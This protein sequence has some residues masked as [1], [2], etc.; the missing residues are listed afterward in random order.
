MSDVRRVQ[1][2]ELFAGRYRIERLL[3]AGGMGAVYI[4]EHL[5]TRRKLALKLMHPEIVA[6][7][8][9]REKFAQEAQ[10]AALIDSP[11]IVD[12]YDAGVDPETGIP[13]IAMELL[14]G[15]EL[16]QMLAEEGR[17]EPKVVVDYIAQVARGLDRAHAAG[18]VHRDLKPDNLFLSARA[19]EPP[20][21]KILD[22]GIAKLTLA[23]TPATTRASGTPVYMAP[24]QT[25]RGAP[26]GA[27]TD[28]W[29]LGLIV[30]KLLTGETYWLSDDLHGLYGEIL[31][32]RY[33]P[34]TAR[35]AEDGVTL[36]PAFDA[37]F[38]RC[39]NLDPSK[40]FHSAG[41][42]AAG[43]ADVF[44]LVVPTTR[45]NPF[46]VAA[47]S[48]HRIV[49]PDSE[50]AATQLTP[51][52][53]VTPPSVPT[54]HGVPMPPPAAE[55]PASQT[56]STSTAL[57]SGRIPLAPPDSGPPWIRIAVGAL[58]GLALSTGAYFGYRRFTKPKNTT[59][60]TQT[61][62]SAVAQI[63]LG[64]SN[65]TCLLS[66]H[67]TVSCKGSSFG[68]KGQQAGGEIAGLKDVTSFAPGK[69][70]ACAVLKDGTAVCWGDNDNGELGDGSTTPRA[71]P[72]KV[73]SLTGVAQI[74]VGLHNSCARL[75]DGTVTCWGSNKYGQLGDGTPQNRATPGV[76]VT[77][78][79]TAVQVALGQDHACA[80]LGNGTVRCWGR[81]ESGQLGDAAKE[82]HPQAVEVGGLTGVAAIGCGGDFSCALLRDST[83]QCWG[84][85]KKGQLGDGTND[86][87]WKP[88]PVPGL[89]DVTKLAV[90]WQHACARDSHEAVRCW[91]FNES[92]QLGDGTTNDRSAP[93]EVP[94]ISFQ[95]EV[96]A[97][98]E[99]TCALRSDGAPVCWG[100]NGEGEL[101][102]GATKNRYEPVVFQL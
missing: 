78:P 64:L 20:R 101:G 57:A 37:W 35:A 79:G 67:G 97:G 88:A 28:V 12:V 49:A 8:G 42:A 98:R 92:G 23:A 71:E 56:S 93:V 24:E 62:K 10:V 95:N 15:K 16:G 66:D 72:G 63:A 65:V 47:S 89:T 96:E 17:L 77:L 90:G 6:D 46:G 91:G 11:N 102:D 68:G 48:S 51:P 39:V 33:E 40:R 73:F 21:V 18:V 82:D 34:A 1:P 53:V 31:S 55:P 38:A 7:S 86:S 3:K 99:H 87:R 100:R 26:L 61:A 84:I 94:G 60:T 81:N 74:A 14:N 19:D 13:F 27:Y 45:T 58:V 52:G 85:N 41:E 36:P 44:G 29:A 25:Q 9:L 30:Y 80:L 50:M 22:F 2:G 59:P 69:H 75:S 83:V 4:A 54:P 76:P 70:H 32:G 5:Q 43:L